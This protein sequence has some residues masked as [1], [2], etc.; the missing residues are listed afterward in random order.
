M[1]IKAVLIDDEINNLDNL[2]LLLQQYCPEV[3]VVAYSTRCNSC[4]KD[5]YRAGTGPGFS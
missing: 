1:K 2:R 5:N 3:A 4:K